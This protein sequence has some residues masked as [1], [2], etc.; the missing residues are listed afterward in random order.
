MQI[1]DLWYRPRVKVVYHSSSTSRSAAPRFPVTNPT[2]SL[3]T[4]TATQWCLCWWRSTMTFPVR[5]LHVQPTNSRAHHRSAAVPISLMQ[6]HSNPQLALKFLHQWSVMR[7]C[8]H[9]HRLFSRR[10]L[11]HDF[12]FFRT[13]IEHWICVP[14]SSS[15]VHLSLTETRCLLQKAENNNPNEMNHTGNFMWSMFT[16]VRNTARMIRTSVQTS[17][18]VHLHQPFRSQLPRYLTGWRTL[19]VPVSRP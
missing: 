11:V 17:K 16:D 7:L 9:T 3:G 12:L 6:A 18:V 1:I 14:I 8:T 10:H 5:M 4:S 13:Q 15:C 2:H 19:F